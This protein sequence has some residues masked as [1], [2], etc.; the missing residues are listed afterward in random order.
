MREPILGMIN[1]KIFINK[2]YF[3]KNEKI[4]P[5]KN[6]LKK[7]FLACFP[8]DFFKKIILNEKNKKKVMILLSKPRKQSHHNPI[9]E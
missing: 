5:V 2:I 8:Q 1:Y 9:S 3:N 6:M 4:F 7:K